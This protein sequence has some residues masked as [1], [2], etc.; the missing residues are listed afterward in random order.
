MKRIISKKYLNWISKCPCVL[1]C[2][3]VTEPHHWNEEGHGGMG[4]KCSDYRAIPLCSHH[5]RDFH[6]HGRET[7]MLNYGIEWQDI[8]SMITWLNNFYKEN[9]CRQ[10]ISRTAEESKTPA[11]KGKHAGDLSPRTKRTKSTPTVNTGG[12]ATHAKA[13]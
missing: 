5:H 9:I 4:T 7:F 12:G 11:K 8:E 13:S 3:E 2:S 1:C 6:D 10:P